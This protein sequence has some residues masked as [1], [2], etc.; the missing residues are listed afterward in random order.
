MV[1]SQTDNSDAVGIPAKHS[2]KTNTQSK[3]SRAVPAIL[4]EQ[5]LVEEPLVRLPRASI[6]VVIRRIFTPFRLLMLSAVVLIAVTGWWMVT[7]R[8]LDEARRIWRREMDV[9]ERA[10]DGK[11]MS[12]L[13]DSLAKAVAAGQVLRRD[14]AEARR[15]T[16]LLLQTKA[17]RELSSSDL[18]SALSVCVDPGGRLDHTR[19]ETATAALSGKWFVFEC[20]LLKSRN[21]L[22]ADLPLIVNSVPVTVT[23]ESEVLQQ[24]VT[25]L[26]QSPLLFVASVETCEVIAGGPE[27]R[28][29]LNGSSCTLVTTEFHAAELGFIAEN[30]PG[31]L[32]LLERQTE[33]LKSDAA[34]AG[35]AERR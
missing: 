15:A 29:Q 32:A 33:F 18:V 30:T 31:L 23:V 9:A 16:S 17:L 22:K 7:Q 12:A 27:F 3:P 34:S 25:A 13:H 6:A 28:I 4:A 2:R 24:A 14:D 19:A 8:R 5:I 26:P 35:K 10:L 21:G 20:P 1:R 11:D